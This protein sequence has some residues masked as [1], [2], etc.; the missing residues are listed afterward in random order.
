MKNTLKHKIFKWGAYLST[1]SFTVVGI[2]LLLGGL[3]YS[4]ITWT[5][6][7][8][9][10]VLVGITILYAYQVWKSN[11]EMQEREEQRKDEEI[12]TIRN[13]LFAEL[14]ESLHPIEDLLSHMKELKEAYKEKKIKWPFEYRPLRSMI[15]RSIIYKI[16]SL[17]EPEVHSI[18]LIYS[19]LNKFYEGYTTFSG[20][21]KDAIIK[22]EIQ[23]KYEG[24]I[25][26]L[27]DLEAGFSCAKDLIEEWLD[28]YTKGEDLSNF[29]ENIS[30]IFN[31]YVEK[32]DNL[33]KH[34]KEFRQAN[35]IEK[36]D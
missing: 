13:L 30:K 18:M 35:K 27:N 11:E 1:V 26:V 29:E 17:P 20:I 12:Q 34:S 15:Y 25:Y 32:F 24:A 8:P 31:K 19:Y 22:G 5:Q 21:I 16:G 6:A 9:T 3:Q 36:E 33:E 10:L 14:A 23:E 4:R 28:F 2:V 7:G